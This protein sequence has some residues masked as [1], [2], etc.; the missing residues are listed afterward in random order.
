MGWVRHSKKVLKRKW[1][2]NF[3]KLE[4]KK[5]FGR[6][7]HRWEDTTAMDHKEKEYKNVNWIHLARLQFSGRSCI[8][9]NFQIP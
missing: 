2:P 5:L 8:Y 6:P 9:C 3:R 1:V 7:R 4:R